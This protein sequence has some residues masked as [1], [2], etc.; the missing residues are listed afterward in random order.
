M[1]LIRVILF[2]LPH[3]QFTPAICYRMPF[4]RKQIAIV[5]AVNASNLLMSA[6]RTLANCYRPHS[7][8]MLTK[9]KI[10][11]DLLPHAQ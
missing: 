3:A 9:N 8:Y 7:Q 5:C 11:R 1:G 6:Q 4:V 2:L 10:F